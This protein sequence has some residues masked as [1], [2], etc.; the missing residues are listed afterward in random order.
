[1]PA[2][3]ALL[4][5]L[6]LVAALGC[7][8]MA[9]LF[10]AFSNFVMK[11]LAE[12]PGSCGMAAMQ[13]INLTVLNPVFLAVFMGTAVLCALL[14]AVALLRWQ[15]AGSAALL[16]GGLLYAV[17]TFGMTL[18]FNVPRNEALARLQAAGADVER[19]W[20]DYRLGW[21]R[22]NHVRTLAALAA[23]ALL[24]LALGRLPAAAP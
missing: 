12:L 6:T 2:I 7:G 10:F 13:S 18:A 15:A 20:R 14:A 5:P 3:E 16:A 1:M 11:A 9:G 21:T 23:A 19:H 4:Y 8:L 17:G 24:T 22:W